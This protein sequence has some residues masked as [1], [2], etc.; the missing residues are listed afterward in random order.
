RRAERRR[1]DAPAS[2][3]ARTASMGRLSRRGQRRGGAGAREDR[4]QEG[5]SLM[6]CLGTI[7]LCVGM[8]WCAGCFT[9]APP[10][11]VAPP[12]AEPVKSVPPV[13]GDGMTSQNYRG[14]PK[15]M[16]EE[17]DREEQQNQVSRKSRE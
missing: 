14:W 16:A 11:I 3:R 4:C 7:A 15:M 17:L 1:R 13:R 5:D 12:A 8:L 9:A 2:G 10:V 6:R